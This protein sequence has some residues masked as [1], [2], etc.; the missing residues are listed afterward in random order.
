MTTR[1]APH[2]ITATRKKGRWSVRAYDHGVSVTVTGNTFLEAVEEARKRLL[3]R[4][5][6][7]A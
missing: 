2:R 7:A 1:R 5:R 4:T 6:R 3:I